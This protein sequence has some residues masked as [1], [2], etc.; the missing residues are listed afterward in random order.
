MSTK[1]LDIELKCVA[2]GTVVATLNPTSQERADYLKNVTVF[3]PQ[4]KPIIQG[5]MPNGVP[6][7]QGFAERHRIGHSEGNKQLSTVSK[8]S[9]ETLAQELEKAKLQ[10]DKWKEEERGEPR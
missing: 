10:D 4:H 7:H 6:N 9:K 3:C 5:R 2:C 8:I 1:N